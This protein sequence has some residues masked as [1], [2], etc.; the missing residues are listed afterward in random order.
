VRLLRL[1]AL[2]PA[3]LLLR[4]RRRRRRFCHRLLGGALG[5]RL[6]TTFEAGP[7]AAIAIGVAVAIE[8]AVAIA[9][10][11]A[12]MIAPERPLMAGIVVAAAVLP[13]LRVGVLRRRLKRGL[14]EATL[15]QQVVAVIV[16]KLVADLAG[17]VRPAQTLLA[18]AVV[19]FARG[20]HLL[21]VSH[22]NAAV[23]FRM[24]EIVLSQHRIA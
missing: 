10:A 5:S 15:I 2:A 18:V 21:S 1:E 14:R 22:N 4:L 17:L 19:A 7:I 13:R 16:G 23:V 11:E 3:R 20:M 9:I 6:R 8:V 24:L 12:P